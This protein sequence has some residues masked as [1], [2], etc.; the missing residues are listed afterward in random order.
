MRNRGEREIRMR[1]KTDRPDG[2]GNRVPTLTSDTKRCII[3][4]ISPDGACGVHG[5]LDQVRER[6]LDSVNVWS[7]DQRL[8]RKQL[9]D[10]MVREKS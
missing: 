1:V 3:Y 5:W 4:N 2:L 7:D 6:E 10:R 9:V 8:F